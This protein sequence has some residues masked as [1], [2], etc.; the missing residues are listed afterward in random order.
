MPDGTAVLTSAPRADD[1]PSTFELPVAGGTAIRIS[2]DADHEDG[3]P[4]ATPDGAQVLFESH[5]SG[6]EG[7]S[8]DLWIIS[9][10]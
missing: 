9:V 3:A 10:P 1:R 8:S 5:R 2:G 7:S 4:C 6:E